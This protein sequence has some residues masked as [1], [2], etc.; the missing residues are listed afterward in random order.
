MFLSLRT[1]WQIV[2]F[3]LLRTPI[4]ICANG[5]SISNS[6]SSFRE[7]KSLGLIN[8]KIKKNEEETTLFEQYFVFAM[9][10]LVTLAF[11]YLFKLIL[12]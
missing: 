10:P 7:H 9:I 5:L 3:P 4:T 12:L 11:G 6:L 8:A 1:L 2:D